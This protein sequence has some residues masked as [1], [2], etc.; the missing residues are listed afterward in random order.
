MSK[1]A[2]FALV[3]LVVLLLAGAKWLVDGVRAVPHPRRT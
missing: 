3:V 2:L 1:T